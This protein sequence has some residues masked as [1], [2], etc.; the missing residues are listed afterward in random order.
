M[1]EHVRFAGYRNSLWWSTVPELK[2]RPRLKGQIEA[3]VTIVGAGFSG[4]WTAYYLKQLNPD[5]HVVIVEAEVA[6]AG[7]SSRNG[8]WASAILPIGWDTLAQQY[9]RDATIR[10]QHAADENLGVMR[11]LLRAE[12]I[13]ADLAA[14]GYLRVATDQA[15]L[16]KLREELKEARSWERS[17]YDATWLNAEETRARINGPDFL[18]GIFI[19]HCMAINPAKLVRGLAEAV[20]RS[21]V[22][23]YERSFVTSVRDGVVTTDRGQVNSGLVV[24]A[25]EG[26]AAQLEGFRRTRLPV[27]STMI[28]TEPLSAELWQELGW[29]KRSTVNDL[30]RHLFYAQRTADGRIA[31]GG[32]GAPYKFASR[33]ELDRNG[34]IE[35]SRHVEDVM[36]EI[37]PMLKGIEVTHRWSGVLGVPRDWTPSVD[38][39]R[40]EKLAM[41]GGYGGDGVALT[42]LAGRT[43][44][45][46]ITGVESPLT[47]L[48]LVGHNSPSWEPEPLRVMGVRLSEKL[49]RRADEVERNTGKP[50]WSG[51]VFSK[52]SG[53]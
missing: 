39:N 37:F 45:H 35:V 49:A 16:A 24:V 2:P 48:P 31:F 30:R 29:E 17:E 23:I 41:I 27:H 47:R 36:Y 50:S 26:Y 44:A 25:V 12:G 51:K 21:G 4:M 19:P 10:Y 18:G 38:V 52:L 34:A 46:L 15:Q 3:D 40:A 28:A 20:E 13:D 22:Q 43:L 53:H 33:V 11:T 6:G 1:A 7:A 8:G 5:I 32:R 14:D 42:H 9:G